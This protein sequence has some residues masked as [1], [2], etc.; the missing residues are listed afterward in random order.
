M[1]R[2]S[3]DSLAI[4]DW[5]N[6]RITMLGPE[7][8]L[9]RSFRPQAAVLGRPEGLF[10][11]GSFLARKNVAEEGP[12]AEGLHRSS[13]VFFR[14]TPSGELAATLPERPGEIRYREVVNDQ[15]LQGT[16]PYT[17][18]MSVATAK[19]RWYY[20]SLDHYEIEVYSPDGELLRLIRRDIPPQPVTPELVEEYREF[21]NEYFAQLPT[22]G[23]EWRMSLPMPDYLPPHGDF[24]ADDEGHLWVPE[25][26]VR[27]AP[28]AW[29]VFDPQGHLLG[30]V[31]IPPGG[32]V[33]QIGTDFVLGF[34]RDEMDVEE[35]RMYGLNRASM[36]REGD[37]V[38][39]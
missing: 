26:A 39:R 17:S 12:I 1:W 14:W 38:G 22:W 33:T 36:E 18:A 6:D 3:Q 5:G 20:S 7:G 2:T 24:L 28:R 13:V 30:E 35:V 16:P 37:V 29:S 4:W 34:W 11:D 27:G 25:Y 15:Q 21:A 19:D 31:E 23:R 32:R 10:G 9:G 8:N